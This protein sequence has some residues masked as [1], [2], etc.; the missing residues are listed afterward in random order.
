MSLPMELWEQ[1]LAQLSIAD[2]ASCARVNRTIS[3]RAF[4]RLYRNIDLDRLDQR[5]C[6]RL[7]ERLRERQRNLLDTIAM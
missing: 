2:L 5:A 1:V 7:Q 4:A 3:E 6:Y